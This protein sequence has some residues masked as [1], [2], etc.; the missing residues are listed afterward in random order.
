VS[1]ERYVG[2]TVACVLHRFHSLHRSTLLHDTRHSLK[3]QSHRLPPE[4]LT[5]YIYHVHVYQKCILFWIT[6]VKIKK[7]WGIGVMWSIGVRELM[8]SL[9][10]II[11]GNREP[12]MVKDKVGWLQMSFGWTSLWDVIPLLQ[13]WH[14]WLADRQEGHPACK[15][16]G[17]GLLVVAIDWSFARIIAPIVTTTFIFSP[18]KSRIVAFCMVLAYPSCPRKRPLNEYCC[19]CCLLK[20][21][22]LLIIFRT[23]HPEGTSHQKKTSCRREAA[24][25]CPRPLWKW[26]P[27][28][29]IAVSRCPSVRPSHSCIVSISL[30]VSRHFSRPGSPISLAF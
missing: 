7:S 13:C 11:R 6:L 5:N 1:V 28:S 9:A 17:I 3:T 27:I 24:T 8:R 22:P 14:C 19:C 12:L 23:K 16:L 2:Y 26:C 18:I 10:T 4:R 15:K 30:K 21:Q 25:I 20:I 29:V